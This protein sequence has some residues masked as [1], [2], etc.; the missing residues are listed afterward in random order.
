MEKY[1][2]YFAKQV[3]NDISPQGKL[4]PAKDVI[5]SYLIPKLKK[6]DKTFTNQ[7]FTNKLTRLP[8]APAKQIVNQVSIDVNHPGP[9]LKFKNDIAYYMAF[10]DGFKN[11]FI[12]DFNTT[13][14]LSTTVVSEMLAKY[15]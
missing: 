5:V 10:N 1:A 15:E 7:N 12:K 4:F 13:N 9:L 8:S 14:K 3:A 11:E 2:N 6:F